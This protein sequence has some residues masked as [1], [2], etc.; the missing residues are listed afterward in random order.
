MTLWCHS[1]KKSPATNN[2]YLD[3]VQMHDL[4]SLVNDNH[5]DNSLKDIFGNLYYGSIVNNQLK[6]CK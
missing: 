5:V 1:D 4:I 2:R 6:N 3:F